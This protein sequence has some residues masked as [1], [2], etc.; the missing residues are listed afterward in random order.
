MSRESDRAR[1]PPSMRHAPTSRRCYTCAMRLALCALALVA[2]CGKRREPPPIVAKEDV[3]KVHGCELRASVVPDTKR[4]TLGAPPRVT[5][6][7]TSD[8]IEPLRILVGGGGARPDFSVD[9]VDAEGHDLPTLDDNSETSGASGFVSFDRDHPYVVKL[10][11][12][13]WL[14][15]KAPGRYDLRVRQM[16]LVGH[17]RSDVET[18]KVSVSTPIDVVE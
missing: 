13:Q 7:L 4:I 1:P 3:A 12:S 9:A 16:L 5:F 2:A 8:C 14:V 18:V 6:R 10:D 15:F 17:S 11:V